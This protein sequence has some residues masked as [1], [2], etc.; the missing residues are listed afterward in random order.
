MNWT[1]QV[2]LRDGRRVRLHPFSHSGGGIGWR[3]FSGQGRG[4]PL[5]EAWLV[6]DPVVPDRAQLRMTVARG[7]RRVGLGTILLETLRANALDVGIHRFVSAPVPVDFPVRRLLAHVARRRGL[8][9]RGLLRRELTLM[10]G[11]E[12]WARSVPR[13]APLPRAL[14]GAPKPHTRS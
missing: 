13:Q 2:V 14:T 4:T 9:V 7:Q 5:G 6:P 12:D 8:R 11:P 10:R 1:F 3:A